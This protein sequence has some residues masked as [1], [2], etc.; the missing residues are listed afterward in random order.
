MEKIKVLIPYDSGFACGGGPT[1][2]KLMFIF[3]ILS[4][5]IRPIKTYKYHMHCEKLHQKTLK[6]RKM[7]GKN[8]DGSYYKEFPADMTLGEL[9]SSLD[10]SANDVDRTFNYKGLK[11]TPLK[12][13]EGD[14]ITDAISELYI[15]YW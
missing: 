15:L 7:E 13:I 9:F 3:K 2:D 12:E 6:E 8:P 5:T 11:E 1:T 14:K 4:W 10:Y